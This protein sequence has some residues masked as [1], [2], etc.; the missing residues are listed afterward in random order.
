ML[1]PRL[2]QGEPIENRVEMT[3]CLVLEGDEI[4]P[5][6]TDGGVQLADLHPTSEDIGL[7]M[8][9]IRLDLVDI[10]G[11][12][13]DITA[14]KNSLVVGDTGLELKDAGLELVDIGA[15]GDDVQIDPVGDGTMGL[16]LSSEV[17]VFA[18]SPVDIA[19]LGENG[20]AKL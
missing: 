2:D 18:V 3:R 17:F 1:H 4:S 8:L 13:I 19:V 15:K 12:T 16:K 5:Q 6:L 7:Q 11:E 14:K 10:L 9:E 20:R